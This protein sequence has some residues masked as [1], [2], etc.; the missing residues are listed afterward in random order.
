MT[1]TILPFGKLPA[2]L[3]NKFIA[4]LPTQ[5]EALCIP[6]GIGRDA[7]GLDFSGKLISVTTDPITFASDRLATYAV[8]VNVNDVACLGCYP[9]WFSGVLLLPQGTT[10]DYIEKLGDEL[11]TALN[12]YHIISIGGHIEITSSVNQAIIIGQMIG[13]AMGEKLLDP[14]HIR[15]GHRILLWQPIAIEGTAL[16]ARE[17]A[18]YLASHFSKEEI[19]RMQN[20]LDSPG[21][22]VWPCVKKLLPMEGIIALHDPTEGGLATALHELA[23]AA[24]SGIHIDYDQILIRAETEKLAQLFK[25]DVLGLLASGS[26]LIVYDP[27]IEKV[28]FQ[29]LAGEVFACIGEFTTNLERKLAYNN[30]SVD[31]PRYSQDSVILALQS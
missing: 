30:K 5:D 3:L 6:P 25:I 12:K 15:P 1:N 20:L 11:A 27:S 16:I 18:E 29:K 14:S 23:D 21:I 13:E 7:A 2:E 31:L 19:I 8:A 17:K 22:C 4:K 28:L 9:K 26:L 10:P 24:N